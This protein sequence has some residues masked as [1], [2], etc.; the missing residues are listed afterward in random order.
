MKFKLTTTAQV[1]TDY[2]V[3]A[4]DEEQARKRLRT[5]IADSE[6]VRPGL[7]TKQAAQR[8]KTPERI[9]E[10][11]EHVEDPPAEPDDA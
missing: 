3:E 10:A 11:A 5:Y 8:N 2:V 9:I 4:E 7:V 6:A 1:E